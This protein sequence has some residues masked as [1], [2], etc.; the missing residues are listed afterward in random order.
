VPNPFENVKQLFQEEDVKIDS[1]FMATRIL[2][3]IPET[4][5][6]AIRL[7]PYS[8]YLP[9][10]AINACFNLCIPKR[11]R[12]PWFHYAKR[13]TAKDKKLKAKIRQA[14]CVNDYHAKQI[15]ELY[16]KMDE[17]PA[18]YFGLKEGE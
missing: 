16:N 12:L 1:P 6:T 17:N 8:T 5:I 2:S 7:N 13:G 15:I 14:F 10:W 11:K 4:C 18:S 9:R 3:F